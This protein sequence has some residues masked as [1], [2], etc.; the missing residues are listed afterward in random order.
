[1]NRRFHFAAGALALFFG[2]LWSG[3]PGSAG[4]GTEAQQSAKP[5]I[6]EDWPQ[7][8]PSLIGR[9]EDWLN[10]D[11]KPLKLK[12]GTVYLIDFW[13]YTCVNCLRTLPYL[14]EWNRR[15]GKDGLVIIGIHAPEFEFSKDPRNV[16]AAVKK[17]GITWPVL[18][19]SQYRNW[20][21][22]HNSFWPRKYFIDSR[23]IIVADHRGEGGYGESEAEIQKLLRQI[24]PGIK[25]PRVMEP[26]RGTDRPGAV[27]Y[28]VTHEI[29]AGYRG[30]A[31]GQHG[32]LDSYTVDATASLNDPGAPHPDGVLFGT[33]PWLLGR[34][35]LRHARE[36]REPADYLAIKYHALEC[37]AV[38]KPEGGKPVRVLVTQ[39]GKPVARADR[40]ADLRCDESGATYI[41]V[42]EPRMYALIKNAQFGS[43]ELKLAST[44]P[45]FGLYSFT[46]SSCE[47]SGGAP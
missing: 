3:E 9:P 47:A 46:F 29:Y 13:E 38:I 1:M 7:P 32:G 6:S 22:F 33:G 11:G 18:I 42:D 30:F 4:T 19:D 40:G 35:S 15:Y 31:T 12:K 41:T 24:H 26:V 16:A 44:S 34:E 20:R 17:L 5:L 28:P 8:A 37:N 43:H 39:D 2:L 27:C 25:F 45:D 10:T 14:Q 23:G 36:T 21:M